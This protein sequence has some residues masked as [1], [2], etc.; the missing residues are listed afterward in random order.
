MVKTH[1]S[2]FSGIGGF[3]LAAEWMGWENVFHCEY[4][5]FPAK[6]LKQNFPNSISYH[7]IKETNFII[8]RGNIYIL[9][10]GFPC[11][12]YS[13]AGKRKGKEDDRHLWPEMLRTIRE[14]QPPWVVGEN[15]FGIVN[16]DGGL[17]FN[18][19]QVE[20]EAEGYEVQ[21]F[22]LPACAINAP[23]RR[24]R[25]WFIAYN[26]SFGLRWEQQETDRRKEQIKKRSN[27]RNINPTNGDKQHV[28]HADS[29]GQQRRDG[30]DEINTG[31]GGKYAF[32][33]TCESIGDGVITNTY[34]SSTKSPRKS[35]KPIGDWSKNDDVK[36]QWG[37][38]AKQHI[39]RTDVLRTITNT[40]NLNG[41]LPIR[42]KS[43]KS[44]S[45]DNGKYANATNYNG[46]RCAEME[47]QP[48]QA[49]GKM[50]RGIGQNR[51]I[52]NWD[53]WPT[54]SGVCGGNDGLSNRVD[55]IKGLGNAIVPQVALQIFKA[56]EQYHALTTP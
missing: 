56:I 6:L 37:K 21:P 32:C 53:S 13:L 29:N 42:K 26:K 20:M 16:W 49:V 47:L 34:G 48:E 8:H 17:V 36:K 9:T 19:V 3:D 45:G 10:G 18:E 23:H 1:G 38:Q 2:L 12:P 40:E 28:A 22:I 43:K 14:I 35:N 55:R 4:A 31:E 25:V 11:Q 41:G 46:I 50:R 5:K 54:K 24:D 30:E 52:T 7:D 51:Q 39:G 44:Q 15:V 33:N 27:I